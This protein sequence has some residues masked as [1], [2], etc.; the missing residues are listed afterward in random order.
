MDAFRSGFAQGLLADFAADGDDDSACGTITVDDDDGLLKIRSSMQLELLLSDVLYLC[1]QFCGGCTGCCSLDGA[2]SREAFRMGFL[3]PLVVGDGGGG[4]SQAVS[5]EA[6]R[7][8][9][10]GLLHV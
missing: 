10:E 1:P 9:L 7:S 2:K 4:G 3:G 6:F 5:M 8:G